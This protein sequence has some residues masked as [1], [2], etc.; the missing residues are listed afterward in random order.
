MLGVF[1][2]AFEDLDTY[3]SKQPDSQYLE[4]LLCSDGFVAVAATVEQRVVG[5]ITG[6]VL[7]KVEQVRSE[8]YIYD[9]AVDEAFRR[10]GVA[11]KCCISTS[12]L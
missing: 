9:L 10:Q 5:G 12:G 2:A 1:G 3:T 11:T 6:D 8:L 7:R 4:R